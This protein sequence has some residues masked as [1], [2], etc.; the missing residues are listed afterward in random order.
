MA[1]TNAIKV[2]LEKLD[3]MPISKIEKMHNTNFYK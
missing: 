2:L 3:I 1:D